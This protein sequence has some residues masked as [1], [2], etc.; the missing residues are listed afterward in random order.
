MKRKKAAATEM[1][2][3]LD[4]I[5]YEAIKERLGVSRTAVSTWRAQ[6]N[7]P[8]H[9]IREVRQILLDALADD[10]EAAPP[11]YWAKRLREDADAISDLLEELAQERAAAL[12]AA[13]LEQPRLLDAGT[14]GRPAA[15]GLS[16]AGRT[17]KRGR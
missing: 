8:L 12:G 5:A 15:G 14:T 11:N 6:D 7:P 3:M 2:R 10:K 9:R 16:D 1:G 4:V 13:D 17:D